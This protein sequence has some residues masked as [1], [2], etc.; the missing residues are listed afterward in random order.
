MRRFNLFDLAIIV[1]VVASLISFSTKYFEK[2]PID[3]YSY[4]GSQIYGAIRFFDLS[5]GKGFRYLVKVDGSYITDYSPFSEEGVV[6]GTSQGSFLLKLQDGRIFTVGGRTSFK[7][8]VASHNIKV[9]MLNGSTVSYLEKGFFSKDLIEAKNRINNTSKFVANY[10]IID[11]TI[12]GDIVIDGN[13][14]NNITF[15]RELSDRIAKEIFYLKDVKIKSSE[16]GIILSVSSLG[17]NDFEKLQ[18]ILSPHGPT[19]YYFPDFRTFVLT[20]NIPKSDIPIIQNNK[21]EGVIGDIH[22]RI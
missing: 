5:D 20:D 14:P 18:S 13:F 17:T 16:N 10:N 3:E 4:T 6:V 19:K 1:L 8:D 12:S 15:Q 21:I 22:V 9:K 2:E 7:E 11:T